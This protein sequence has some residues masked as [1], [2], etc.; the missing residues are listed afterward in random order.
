MAALREQQK[1]ALAA[2][3]GSPTSTPSRFSTTVPSSPLPTPPVAAQGA[4]ADVLLLRQQVQEMRAAMEKARHT[5]AMQDEKVL[6][7]SDNLLKLGAAARVQ[8]LLYARHDAILRSVLLQW[9]RNLAG[10]HDRGRQS[11]LVMRQLPGDE[12]LPPLP[13]D[14]ALEPHSNFLEMVLLHLQ[15]SALSRALGE[16]ARAVALVDRQKARAEQQ[17]TVLHGKWAIQRAFSVEQQTREKLTHSILRWW[18]HG[19]LARGWRLWSEG[20]AS[21]ARP[22]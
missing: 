6:A 3:T 14:P 19:E 18:F 4:E 15:P 12:P 2:I 7:H 13:V 5:A 11:L 10:L 21:V 9:Q 20:C 22:R 17:Q 1:A 8:T 16:W